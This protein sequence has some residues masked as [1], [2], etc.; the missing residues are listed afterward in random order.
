[1]KLFGSR[2]KKEK[3]SSENHK[4]MSDIRELEIYSGMKV[5]VENLEGSCYLLRNYRNYE[6]IRRSF[7][8][9]R[10]PEYPV[11]MKQRIFRKWLSRK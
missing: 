7:I 10:R 8:S 4:K 6:E 1:M 5:V 11:K 3:G 2:K 9:I